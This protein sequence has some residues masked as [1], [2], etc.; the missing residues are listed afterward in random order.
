MAKYGNG[1]NG[2]GGKKSMMSPIYTGESGKSLGGTKPGGP[3][4]GKSVPD[5]IGL[6]HGKFAT[7]PSAKSGPSQKHDKA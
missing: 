5:P 2:G 1:G 6:T 3:M 4:G 7:G